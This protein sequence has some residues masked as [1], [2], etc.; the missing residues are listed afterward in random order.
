V[1]NNGSQGL[2]ATSSARLYDAATLAP[3]GEVP[4]GIG[5]HEGAFSG[6]GHRLVVTSASD[7]NNLI[8]VYDV[9]DAAAPRGIA[10]FTAADSGLGC[11]TQPLPRGCA[12]AAGTTVCA[13]ATSGTLVV[14]GAD[15]DPPTF[16]LV[17]THGSG[18]G[19]A[20]AHPSAG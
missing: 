19:F 20:L 16:R 1:L 14:V 7:C 17:A 18:G 2:A 13:L 9:R 3:R 6:G 5:D 8:S 11:V 10:T 12:T 15:A 4:L